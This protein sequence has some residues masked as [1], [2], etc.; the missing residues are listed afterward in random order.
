M[1]R[2]CCGLVLA[3]LS[4]SAAAAWERVGVADDGMVVYADPA[5]IQ[6]SGDA[7]KMWTLLD[8]KIAEKDDTG[9]PYLSAKLLHEYHCK[10]ERART[11]YF[12]VHA[13]QM[14]AGR[15][16]FSEVRGESDWL[17]A[18]RTFIGETLWRIACGKK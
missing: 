15:L 16:V 10:D 3:A 6:K 14:A 13:G 18:G 8:Y 17:P 11:R 7:V 2:L 12:S 1:K 4:G 9:Q 5:T